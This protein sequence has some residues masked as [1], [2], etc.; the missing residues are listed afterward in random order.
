MF[1]SVCTF[2]RGRNG[3]R[4]RGIAI[5]A[6]ESDITTVIDSD[7]SRVNILQTYDLIPVEGCFNA[8]LHPVPAKG[9]QVGGFVDTKEE[10]K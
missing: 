1:V 6:S 7:G 3:P 2:K 4:E 8:S 9:Q 10:G 5:G